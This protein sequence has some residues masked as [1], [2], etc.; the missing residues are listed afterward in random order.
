MPRHLS[1]VYDAY[2]NFHLTSKVAEKLENGEW[3]YY[4]KYATLTYTDDKGV[5]H[6][7]EG[8]TDVD[9]KRHN[10]GTEQWE[11]GDAT[12]DEAEPTVSDLADP[13]QPAPAPK[14]E[15]EWGSEDCN[16]ASHTI[17]F[18]IKTDMGY[19]MNVCDSC[20]V[21][22]KAYKEEDRQQVSG[23]L[24]EIKYITS[25]DGNTI[26]PLPVPKKGKGFTINKEGLC[27]CH[28]P[29]KYHPEFVKPSIICG[30]CSKDAGAYGNNPWPLPFEKVC[31]ECNVNNVIP[32]RLNIGYYETTGDYK[33]KDKPEVRKARIEKQTK[34]TIERFSV[35]GVDA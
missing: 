17:H 19:T 16:E 8:N 12:D 25:L 18:L 9:Y 4:I 22:I 7:V 3:K 28:T 6:S 27:D 21:S 31:D 5:E 23:N 35:F 13:P 34:E 15:C 10:E 29:P 1:V 32:A 20:C 14:V 26:E 11:D 33:D 30:L 2:A 24:S